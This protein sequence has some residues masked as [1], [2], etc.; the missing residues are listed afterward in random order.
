MHASSSRI[1]VQAGWRY[2]CTARS[3]MRAIR[4]MAAATIK[5]IKTGRSL[6]QRVGRWALNG[7]AP[8]AA[9]AASHCLNEGHFVVMIESCDKSLVGQKRSSAERMRKQLGTEW[10]HGQDSNGEVNTD[11]S[12][13]RC[14][15]STQSKAA[16][17][18]AE[19]SGP[20]SAFLFVPAPSP[21]SASVAKLS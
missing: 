9:P 13:I 21:V 17:M 8:L 20:S 2:S 15:Q 1:P 14:A 7:R 11:G 4:G 10:K 6:R 19:S 5:R 3:R 16:Q 18:P 12:M